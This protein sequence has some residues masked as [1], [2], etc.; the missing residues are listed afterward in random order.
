MRDYLCAGEQ[1]FPKIT[2]SIHLRQTLRGSGAVYRSISEP[3]SQNW[4]RW[5]AASL[6]PDGHRL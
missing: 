6:R 1:A 2:Q 3:W 4:S 5:C